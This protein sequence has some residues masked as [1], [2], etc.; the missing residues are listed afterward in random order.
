M[1]REIDRGWESIHT[2][3]S[4][5]SLY[6]IFSEKKLVGENGGDVIATTRLMETLVKLGG[7]TSH[8]VLCGMKWLFCL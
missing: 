6:G 3:L 1:P 5:I 8:F 7:N 2:G 4:E